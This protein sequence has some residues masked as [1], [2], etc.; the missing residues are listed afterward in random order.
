[1]SVPG[2]QPR[3]IAGA[4]VFLDLQC[5]DNAAGRVTLR[6]IQAVSSTQPRPI[7]GAFVFLGSVLSEVTRDKRPSVLA[8]A[9]WNPFA[10]DNTR[11]LVSVYERD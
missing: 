6:L 7:A 8:L 11:E 10:N 9:C 1:M 2:L 5:L 3:F 4:V